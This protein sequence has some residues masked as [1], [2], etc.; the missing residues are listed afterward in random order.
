MKEYFLE[1]DVHYL[2]K[3]PELHNDLPFLPQRMKIE[4]VE[5]LAASL[6]DKNEYFIHIRNLKQ[7]LNHELFLKKS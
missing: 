5:K 1:L 2:E 3:L 7:A 6:N 4:K